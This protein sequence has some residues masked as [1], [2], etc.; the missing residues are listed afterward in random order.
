MRRLSL[1]SIR[2]PQLLHS[3]KNLSYR[4]FY[5]HTQYSFSSRATGKSRN[6]S[7]NMAVAED[8]ETVL[9]GKY[10]AKLHAKK[11]ADWI[12]GKGGD[13]NGTIYLEAQKQ[14]LQEVGSI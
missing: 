6:Y 4:C 10:P 5:R 9:K 3:S 14:K 1:H 13:K 7:I 8:Y 12:V 11:V 2:L